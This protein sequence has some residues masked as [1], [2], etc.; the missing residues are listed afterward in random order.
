MNKE[1][2][3]DNQIIADLKNRAN[4]DFQQLSSFSVILFIIIFFISLVLYIVYSSLYFWLPVIVPVGMFMYSVVNLNLKKKM[5]Y[6]GGYTVCRDV[7]IGKGECQM[8]RNF[9]RGFMR[10]NN[11]N[12]RVDAF[13]FSYY[14]RYA[15]VTLEE[16]TLFELS[17]C[18]EEFYLV[19]YNNRKEKPVAIYNSKLYERKES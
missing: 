5:I 19:V 15:A 1:K 8:D 6:N 10:R 18:G 17:E 16:K 4:R 13:Y 3:S 2:L 9:V 11:R 14:G 7:L 12:N